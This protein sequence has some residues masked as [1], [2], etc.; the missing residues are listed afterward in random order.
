VN[1]HIVQYEIGG[2]FKKIKVL[3]M[4]SWW[5]SYL[6]SLLLLLWYTQSCSVFLMTIMWPKWKGC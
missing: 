5:I 1:V 2:D 3:L 6:D 4:Q